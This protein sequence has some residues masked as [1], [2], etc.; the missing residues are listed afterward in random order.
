MS[1]AGAC[2]LMIVRVGGCYN[3]PGKMRELTSGMVYGCLTEGQNDRKI[4][5]CL[6]AETHAEIVEPLRSRL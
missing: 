5:E 3:N 4:K 1:I 2:Q 6:I